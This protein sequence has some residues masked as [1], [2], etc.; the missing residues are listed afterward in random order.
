[1]QSYNFPNDFLWGTAT[2]AYQIEGAWNADG[3]SDSI[4]DVFCRKE[5]A[6]LNGDTGNIACD[7]Y[8]KYKEDIQLLKTLNVK[9]Y[10]FSIAWSRIFPEG[11]GNINKRGLEFY[12][13]LIELLI[14]NQIIPAATIYHWDLPQKLQDIGGWANPKIVEYFGEYAN[15]LFNELGDK[16]K[17]WITHNEPLVVTQCGH[18]YGN[19]APGIKDPKIAYQVAHHLLMSHGQ[20]VKKFRELNLPNSQ[21]GITLNLLPFYTIKNTDDNLYA[22]DL[23]HANTNRL[24]LDPLFKGSYPDILVKALTKCNFMPAIQVKDMDLIQ[25][26]IDYLGV[27]YYTRGMVKYNSDKFLCMDGDKPIFPTTDI[28]WEIYPEGMYEVLEILN[29]EYTKIPLYI[30]ENGASFRDFLENG[31]IQDDKRLSYLKEHFKIA[32]RAIQDGIPLKGYYVWSY[33]DNF[34]WAYGFS[35]RF[36]I[37]YVDYNTKERI[38]KESGNWVRSVFTNNSFVD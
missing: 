7:H 14:E 4:W 6:I 16:V 24:F 33:M 22:R 23:H 5:N 20:A 18:L 17:L 35:E 36:G 37:V 38:V 12:K 10:R 19:H 3:K 8:N 2:S 26:P 15:C 27:N 32:H 30:T 34:E 13:N 29:K 9:S 1:M 25:Q 21:I 11:F 31:R 28:G